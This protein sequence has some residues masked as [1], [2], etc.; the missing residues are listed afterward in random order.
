MSIEYDRK[1]DFI[2]SINDERNYFECDEMF[3]NTIIEIAFHHYNG[4][5]RV[6][7]FAFLNEKPI[8]WPWLDKT[9]S[10]LKINGK[11]PSSWSYYNIGN[12]FEIENTKKIEMLISNLY[13]VAKNHYKF[14]QIMS[15]MEYFKEKIPYIHYFNG[16]E[17]GSFEKNLEIE[18]TI[19]LRRNLL[20]FGFSAFPP[21][22]PCDYCSVYMNKQGKHVDRSK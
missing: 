1:R 16:I 6:S 5:A 8:S 19:N 10:I 17:D 21:Y 4:G 3:K 18:K 20:E 11:V 15:T 14:L 7:N 9:V 2:A 12:D 13:I 22:F